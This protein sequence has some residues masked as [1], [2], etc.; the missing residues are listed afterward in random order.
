MIGIIQTPL[1]NITTLRVPGLHDVPINALLAQGQFA[2]G[3][4][5]WWCGH[6]LTVKELAM[7]DLIN[8]IT[9]RP[10]WHR[11]IFDQQVITQW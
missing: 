7:L 9:D 4:N 8:T 10:D 2:A 6:I 1:D 11:A 5:R 3:T